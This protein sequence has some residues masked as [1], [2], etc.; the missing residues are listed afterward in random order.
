MRMLERAHLRAG[1]IVAFA[2]VS[3]ACG[4]ST[5]V[6]NESPAKRCTGHGRPVTPAHLVRVFRSHGI[7]LEINQR[8][9]RKG[10]QDA[11]DADAT[12]LGPKAIRTTAGVNDVEGMILCDVATHSRFG[13]RVEVIKYETDEETYVRTLNVNCSVY[14]T[15]AG[16]R[17]VA[18]LTTAM[19]AVSQAPR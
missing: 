17:Q 12:N 11:G 4:S 19:R 5:K 14:P 18:R 2:L 10:N 1:A 9:C 16:E 15:S 8:K 13:D 6:A 7:H 3:G